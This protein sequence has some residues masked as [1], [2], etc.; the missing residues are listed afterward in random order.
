MLYA[1]HDVL[2]LLS[3]S[4]ITRRFCF[5]SILDAKIMSAAWTIIGTRESSDFSILSVASGLLA[6]ESPLMDNGAIF[7]FI[8]RIVMGSMLKRI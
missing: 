5:K 3:T 2:I 4:Y 6:K 7:L 8:E 1:G